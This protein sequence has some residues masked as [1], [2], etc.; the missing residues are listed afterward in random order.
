MHARRTQEWFP[1]A[2]VRVGF[3]TLRVISLIPTPGD[4][5][6]DVYVLTDPR[7]PDRIYHFTPH[8]GLTRES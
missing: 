2:L 7:H 8:F 1:G 6:P 3:L 4:H 5:R